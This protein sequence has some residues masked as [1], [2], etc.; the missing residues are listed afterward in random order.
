MSE[1]TNPCARPAH[2]TSLKSFSDGQSTHSDT[3][4]RPFVREAPAATAVLAG[5]GCIPVGS[6]YDGTEALQTDESVGDRPVMAPRAKGYRL[7]LVVSTGTKDAA[8]IPVQ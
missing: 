3:P 5:R 2:G 7:G 6:N 8:L 1:V 4:I